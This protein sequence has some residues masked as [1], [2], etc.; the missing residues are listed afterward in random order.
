MDNEQSNSRIQY[1]NKLNSASRQQYLEKNQVLYAYS[2]WSSGRHK[3]PE[4]MFPGVFGYLVCGVSAYTHE[5]FRNYKSLEAA[6]Y[7]RTGAGSSDLQSK[8]PPNYFPTAE[9]VNKKVS[10]HTS[11]FTFRETFSLSG[12][13]TCQRTCIKPCK[14]NMLGFSFYQEPALIKHIHSG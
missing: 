2:E 3:L 4:V 7:Q 14:V 9:Q 11:K 1:R 8:S 12:N 6:V 10:L 13:I 5:Q